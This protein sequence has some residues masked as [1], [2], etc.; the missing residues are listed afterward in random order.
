MD[1]F[2]PVIMKI[3]TTSYGILSAGWASLLF[4]AFYWTIDVRGF[5]KWAFPF[6]VIG[7]NALAIYMSR[8]LIPLSQTIGI[9]TQPIAATLGSFGPLFRECSVLV[10]E[11]LILYW[12]YRRK[13]FLRA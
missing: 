12:M 11:W 8:T 6:V 7:M 5:R 4:L 9:F 2:V 13:I 3:W 10:V 1:P